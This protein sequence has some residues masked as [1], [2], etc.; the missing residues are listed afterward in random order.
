MEII[1][2]ETLALQNDRTVLKNS[3][4]TFINGLVVYENSFGIAC[5]RALY[6]NKKF[7]NCLVPENYLDQKC[8][9]KKII[10]N[11]PKDYLKWI[12]AYYDTT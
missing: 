3:R 1:G 6:P 10:L 12:K 9:N 5:I 2:T 4:D 8:T 7:S 11:D